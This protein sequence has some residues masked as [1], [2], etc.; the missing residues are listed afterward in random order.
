MRGFGITGG[1]TQ[2]EEEIS[3]GLYWFSDVARLA[4]DQ[5]QIK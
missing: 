5:G 4:V 3:V 1:P 2:P